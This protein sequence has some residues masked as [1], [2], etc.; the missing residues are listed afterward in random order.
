MLMDNKICII[1]I[2]MLDITLF[3]KK[4]ILSINYIEHRLYLKTL[5]NY[6]V[7]FAVYVFLVCII[8]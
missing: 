2:F 3:K 6:L 7:I 8:L 5:W 1:R 4:Y